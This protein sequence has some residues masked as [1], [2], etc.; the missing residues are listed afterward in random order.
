IDEFQSHK[1]LSKGPLCSTESSRELAADCADNADQERKTKTSLVP[2]PCNPRHPRLISPVSKAIKTAFG[3]SSFP[4]SS[5]QRNCS[6]Y[7]S[8]SFEF[9]RTASGA[10]L[11]PERWFRCPSQCAS[12]GFHSGS[13]GCAA[14][15][16]S[17]S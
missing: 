3:A 7:S 14:L 11:P 6:S 12:F 15:L 16:P 10:G 5:F 17:W 4:S 8:S 13:D 9:G 2:C 1:P